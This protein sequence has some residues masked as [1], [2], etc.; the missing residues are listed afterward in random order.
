MIVPKTV[1]GILSDLCVEYLYEQGKKLPSFGKAIE[2]G[3]YKG[4]STWAIMSGINAGTGNAFL[5]SVD[6][7]QGIETKPVST[8]D[9][10]FENIKSIWNRDMIKV[11]ECNSWDAAK[12]FENES[13]DFI[14]IDADHIY[15]SVMKDITA[16]WPKIKKCGIM[17]GHDFTASFDVPKAVHSFFDNSG[18]HLRQIKDTSIWEVRK[19]LITNVD[20]NQAKR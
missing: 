17:S 10:F 1:E 13:I 20:N 3:V 6:N 7:W 19:E 14:F 2:L 4:K 9:I 18:Y 11:I 12:N 16:W 5:Y 15:D 8:K